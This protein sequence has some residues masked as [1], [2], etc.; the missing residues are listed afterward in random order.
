M[1]IESSQLHMQMEHA[2]ESRQ[3]TA[4]V[5]LPPGQFPG[6]GDLF[7]QLRRQTA[8]APPESLA[9]QRP[10][11]P[12]DPGL[13]M[14][15]IAAARPL[16][17]EGEDRQTR[18]LRLVEEMLAALE[19]LLLEVGQDR[20]GKDCDFREQLAAASAADADTG[21]WTRVTL[22]H[23]Q[24]N[25]N[26]CFSGQG[27]VRTA[28]GREIRF[29][30]G[31]SMSR[32]TEET[33]L[34]WQSGSLSRLV[35]PLILNFPG[36]GLELAGSTIAFDLTA[37]GLADRLPLLAGASGYLAFD[38]NGDGRIND[39]R[40]LFGPLSGNGFAD[41]AGLDDDG[42]RWIDAGDRGFHELLLWRPDATGRGELLNLAELGIGALALQS[43]LTPFTLKDGA[44]QIQAMLRQSG[45]WLGEK[46]GAGSLMHM[47]V[48]T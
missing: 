15:N 38:R 27:C 20:P 40:E 5:I 11:L 32:Q 29:D 31:F 12:A 24:E 36:R 14:A 28:D 41:L 35:D 34:A 25:E 3:A 7:A 47:D 1:R 21:Q 44:G 18:L 8:A 46:G 19:A 39:G 33:R 2:S 17:Q 4:S 30:M 6:F 26:L 43:L 16:R 48:A 22:T 42:N 37:D 9:G 45:L 23:S 10:H 13:P